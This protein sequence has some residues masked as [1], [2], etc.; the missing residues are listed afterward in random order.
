MDIPL[1][2]LKELSKFKG[3]TIN[4]VVM[5]GLS[6]ALKQVFEENGEKTDVIKMAL[7]ANLRF[8]FYK[9]RQHIKL[10]NKFA[11]IPITVPLSSSM[12]EAYVK[13]KKA[14]KSLKNSMAI[15]YTTYAITSWSNKLLP[16]FF[17]QQTA[18]ETIDKFTIALSNVPGIVKIP[19]YEDKKTGKSMRN[20]A[21]HTYVVIA[22]NIGMGF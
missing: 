15:I 9:T 16:R 18:N 6:T 19:T 1:K 11:A 4:D 10:E 8:K 17:V 5:A 20:I 14:T 13:I 2:D 12:D 21:S 7:P 22:G 3:V